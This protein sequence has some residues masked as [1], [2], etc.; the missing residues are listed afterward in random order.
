MSMYEFL[1]SVSEGKN[2]IPSFSDGAYI[3]ALCDA[4]DISDREGR[5]V[6]IEEILR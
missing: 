4:A 5:W 1:R 2:M 3:A 6:R